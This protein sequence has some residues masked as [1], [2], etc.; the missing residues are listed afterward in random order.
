MIDTI[1]T[2]CKNCV[3]AQYDNQTQTGCA[4]NFLDKFHK[5]NI[6]ILEVYDNDKAF[7]VINKKKCLGYRENKWF[8]QYN[9]EDA[10]IEEKIAKFKEFNT[11]Q[12][13]V[14]IDLKYFTNLDDLASVCKNLM[15]CSIK[16]QSII[17]IRH[18]KEAL[19]DFTLSNIENLIKECKISCVWRVQSILDDTISDSS[20]IN[21]ILYTNTKHR[22]VAL[23]TGIINNTN[24]IIEANRIVHED[25]DRIYLLSNPEHTCKVFGTLVYRY[26]KKDDVDILSKTDDFIIIV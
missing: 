20:I 11:L 9:L 10:S 2:P 21:T 1:H 22:F 19:R 16:P 18:R 26:A 24:V 3:F 13:F 5:S 15:A 25:M 6:E 14:I 12:Y 7:Y 23:I 8:N 17:F 4:L